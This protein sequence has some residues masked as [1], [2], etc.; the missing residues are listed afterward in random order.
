M[1]TNVIHGV[2]LFKNSQKVFT[3]LSPKRIKNGIFFPDVLNFRPCFSRPCIS[4]HR[5]SVSMPKQGRTTFS[6]IPSLAI[7]LM[8]WLSR[9]EVSIDS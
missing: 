6:E 8:I 4:F 7:G 2:C 5:G 1:G 3:V 9:R